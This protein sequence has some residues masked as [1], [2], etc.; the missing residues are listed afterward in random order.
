[1]EGGLSLTFQ[2]FFTNKNQQVLEK[3]KGYQ[4]I[5]EKKEASRAAPKRLLYFRDG[6]SEGEFQQIKDKELKDLR[7]ASSEARINPKLTF[8]VVGKRH[9]Y[10]FCPQD[11]NDMTQADKSG[12]CPAGMVHGR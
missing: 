3:Y 7:E 4:A 1:M 10:R 11:P 5:V 2:V 9:H 6:V 12:N 8:I